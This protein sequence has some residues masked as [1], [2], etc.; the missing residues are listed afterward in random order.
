MI[1]YVICD[2]NK[3][4][5][6]DVDEIINRVMMTTSYNY[7]VHKFE[8]N[9]GEL[10]QIIEQTGNKIYIIDIEMPGTSGIEIARKIR[11][12]D[13]NSMI[14][15]LSAHNELSYDIFKNRLMILDFVSKFD[16][17]KQELQELLNIALE[18][19]GKS[20]NI[21][22]QQ[23]NMLYRVPINDI[24]Y[25]EKVGGDK[26]V[27]IKT[28][29]ENVVLSQSLSI[30]RKTLDD[31]FIQTHRSCIVNALKIKKVNFA[32]NEIIFQN[33]ERISYLSKGCKKEL[34]KYV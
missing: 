4:M 3:E 22:F 12:H 17:Y 7:R 25:I 11:S 10:E 5:L 6:K 31:N 30:I 26:K 15:V 9:S 18:G 34:R 24:M 14:I 13:W 19:I 28:E 21:S 1:D 20:K 32:D 8:R 29:K 2:D 33:G 27:V 23:D 16:N